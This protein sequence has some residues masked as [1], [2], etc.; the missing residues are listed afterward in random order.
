MDPQAWGLALVVT[1]WPTLVFAA[2]PTP[3]VAQALFTHA[4]VHHQPVDSITRLSGGANQIYYFADLRNM[5][6]QTV[7]ERWTYHGRLVAQMFF[8]V[9]GPRWRV[10][11][12]AQLAPSE[13]GVWQAAVINGA[14]LTLAV[15]TLIYQPDAPS[16]TP[17]QVHQ[18][19]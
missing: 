6:G 16:G 18:Q 13:P 7:T 3:Y 14:G 17:P 8:Q 11:T 1:G 2:A 12:R 9:R 10:Y 15:N 5:T 4:V 19:Q